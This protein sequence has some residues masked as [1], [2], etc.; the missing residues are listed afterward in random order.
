MVCCEENSTES[1]ACAVKIRG[2]APE[3]MFYSVIFTVTVL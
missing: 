3:G 1:D 2:N